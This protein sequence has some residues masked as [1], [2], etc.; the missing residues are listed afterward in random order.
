L[1]GENGTLSKSHTRAPVAQLDRAVAS[2][3]LI[4][5]ITAIQCIYRHHD[6]S[7]IHGQSNIY[8]AHRQSGNVRAGHCQDSA[9]K[10]VMSEECQI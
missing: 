3:N 7:V 1:A 5:H 6:I 10:A 8:K 2:E 9:Q 4:W